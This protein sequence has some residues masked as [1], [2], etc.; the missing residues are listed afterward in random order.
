MISK[1][2]IY[3]GTSHVLI[4][5]GKCNKA[6]GINQRERHL[7]S[8]EDEDDYEWLADDE[9]GEAPKDP[10]SYEG[11]DAKPICDN[12]KLNRWCCR[13][14]ERSEMLEKNKVTTDTNFESL[15]TD[16]S[17]RKKNIPDKEV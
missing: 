11:G 7:L 10:H 15:L 1:D 9:L 12:E 13:E 14:C 16:F 4:C 5:D 2:I 17:V 6:W 3:F 8:D